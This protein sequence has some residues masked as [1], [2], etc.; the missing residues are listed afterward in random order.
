[1]LQ[2]AEDSQ[3]SFCREGPEVYQKDAG[4]HSSTGRPHKHVGPVPRGKTWS[5]KA[6]LRPYCGSGKKLK[7]NKREQNKIPAFK[8]SK[9]QDTG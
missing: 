5:I 6:L 8:D 7:Q 4:P 3:R 2:T 9:N 1:M